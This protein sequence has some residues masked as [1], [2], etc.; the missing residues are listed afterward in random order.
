[1]DVLQII[2]ILDFRP[3]QYLNIIKII[4]KLHRSVM[5]RDTYR[6]GA[7]RQ[8]DQLLLLKKK[9]RSQKIMWPTLLQHGWLLTNCLAN[10]K[11][12]GGATPP[13][14]HRHIPDLVWAYGIKPSPKINWIVIAVFD[15]SSIVSHGL[16]AIVNNK[17]S[18]VTIQKYVTWNKP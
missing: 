16:T 5:C 6:W 2:K 18:T 3:Y 14:P 17:V 11:L 9:K 15:L 1:M 12:L 4:F 8:I 10:L 7:F 13:C